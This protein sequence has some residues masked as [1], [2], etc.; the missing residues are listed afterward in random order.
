MEQC[1]AKVTALVVRHGKSSHLVVFRQVVTD[2]AKN[3]ITDSFHVLHIAH[4]HLVYDAGRPGALGGD[5]LETDPLLLLGQQ[6][7]VTTAA[8]ESRLCE[9]GTRATFLR[10]TQ[11]PRP[12]APDRY[13][14]G[15][16][17]EQLDLIAGHEVGRERLVI[18]AHAPH[19]VL[20]TALTDL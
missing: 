19:A 15:A 20:L 9:R 4:V 7:V 14:H 1:G 11:E 17:K 3:G 2:L 10:S 5:V 12:T 13:V 16:P 18:G 6:I 8:G